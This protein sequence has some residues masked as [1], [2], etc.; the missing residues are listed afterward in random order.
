MAYLGPVSRAKRAAAIPAASARSGPGAGARLPAGNPA[1]RS[2]AGVNDA[3]TNTDAKIFAAGL[4]AGIAVGAGTALLL[5]PRTGVETRYALG[6]GLRRVRRR[7]SDAWDDLRDELRRA[8]AW[9]R[10]RRRRA[11]RED[12]DPLDD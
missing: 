11:A 7:G 1:I 3:G 4:I 10:R 12:D 2:L 8:S 6:R 9:R 5:A